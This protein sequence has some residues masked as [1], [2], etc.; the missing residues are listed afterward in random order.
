MT[1]KNVCLTPN[2]GLPARVS[3][4]LAD[5][6]H[7]DFLFCWL[8]THWSAEWVVG[9]RERPQQK[10]LMNNPLLSLNHKQKSCMDESNFVFQHHPIPGL[11]LHGI[12]YSLLFSLGFLSLVVFLSLFVH[13]LSQTSPSWLLPCNISSQ[14]RCNLS[15]SACCWQLFCPSKTFLTRCLQLQRNLSFQI[16]FCVF[17]LSILTE[18]QKEK[19]RDKSAVGYFLQYTWY[20]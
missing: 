16:V 3:L 17:R 20:D 7:Q 19:S 18:Q 12:V 1:E 4:L 5:W 9:S 2:T 15:F 6:V 8:T 10:L 11:F 13:F 14:S